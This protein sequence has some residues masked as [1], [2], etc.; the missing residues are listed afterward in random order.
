[1]LKTI[2]IR[3]EKTEIISQNPL[4]LKFLSKNQSIFKSRHSLIPFASPSLSGF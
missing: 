2:D 1:M 3:L 4:F